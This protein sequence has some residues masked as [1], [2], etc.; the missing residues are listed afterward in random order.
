MKRGKSS[1]YAASVVLSRPSSVDKA[2]LNGSHSFH[3]FSS[4][5]YLSTQRCVNCRQSARP[6]ASNALQRLELLSYCC[7]SVSPFPRSRSILIPTQYIIVAC[8]CL[9][10][11]RCPPTRIF[12]SDSLFSISS[13]QSTMMMI[14]S[15]PATVAARRSVVASAGNTKSARVQTVEECESS[16]PLA[17]IATIYLKHLYPSFMQTLPLSL[18]RDPPADPSLASGIL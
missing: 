15:A 17:T 6:R 8:A 14:K 7:C 11:A 12:L 16:Y 13:A 4:F 10:L 9:P 3:N 1:H 18:D 2:T 5:Y